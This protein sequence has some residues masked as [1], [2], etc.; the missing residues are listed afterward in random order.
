MGLKTGCTAT[1]WSVEDKGKYSEVRISTSHKNKGTQTWE[2]DF[3]AY[4]RFIGAA[5]EAAKTLAPKDRIRITEFEVTNRYDKE[6]KTTY[7]SYAIFKFEPYV[8]A[9]QPIPTPANNEDMPF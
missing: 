1:I 4:V 2:T 7:T 6:R 8:P 3:G 9:E 5:H